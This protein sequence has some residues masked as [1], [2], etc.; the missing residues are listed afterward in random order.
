MEHKELAACKTFS[1]QE[2]PSTE[3]V[4]YHLLPKDLKSE[5]LV[6]QR[7]IALVVVFFKM[8]WHDGSPEQDN[9]DTHIPRLHSLLL[10]YLA[11]NRT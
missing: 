8:I 4:L 7:S 1:P 2:S 5:N 6:T 10:L 11:P 9:Y 3:A